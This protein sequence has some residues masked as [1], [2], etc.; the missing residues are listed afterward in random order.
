MIA[1]GSMDGVPFEVVNLVGGGMLGCGRGVGDV[2]V[3][4]GLWM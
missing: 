4:L 3:Q 1:I 2:E